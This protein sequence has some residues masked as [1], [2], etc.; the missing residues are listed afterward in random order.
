MHCQLTELYLPD[1]GLKLP[2]GLDILC[3]WNKVS[4]FLVL[5]V[6]LLFMTIQGGYVATHPLLL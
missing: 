2:L 4:A 5:K 3:T 1:G 6:S